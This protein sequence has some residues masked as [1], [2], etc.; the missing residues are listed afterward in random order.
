MAVEIPPGPV[1]FVNRDG[2]RE[3]VRRAIDNRRGRTRPL[4]VGLS[5]PGGSGKTELA[6]ML[7]RELSERFPDVFSVDLDEFRVRG[8]FDAND[9]LGELLG[10]LGVEPALWRASFTARCR[11]YWSLTARRRMVLV[12]DNVRYA[13]EVVPLLPASGDSVVIVVSHGPL[14]DLEDGSALDLVLPPLEDEPAMELLRRIVT[15]G[16][17]EADPDTARAVVRLCS[18]LPAALRVAGNRLRRH[19]L[20]PLPKL[21]ADLRAEL[22]DRGVPVVEA[23][24]DASHAELSHDAAVL[25]RLLAEHPGPTFTRAS[26]TALFGRGP[27]ACDAALEE[28]DG[29]GLV[30]VRAAFRGGDGRMRMPELMRAHARR[31]PYPDIGEREITQAHARVLRWWTRQFQRADLFAAGER[32]TVSAPVGGTAGAADVGPEAPDGAASGEEKRARRRA[33]ARWLYEERHT[34]FAC[35]RLAHARGM[36]DE[37]VALC[38]VLWTFALDHP[39]QSEVVDLYRLGLES[40]LRSGRADRVVRMRC[41]LARPLWEAGATEEAASQMDAAFA[42]LDLLGDSDRDRKLRASAVEFRGMLDAATGDLASAAAR[43]A[44]CRD[45]HAAIPNPYGVMLATYRLGQVRARLGDLD[46][47][48]ELLERAH[49]DAAAQERERMTARTGFALGHVLRRLGRSGQARPLYEESLAGARARRSE[50]DELRVLEALA[51]LAGEEGRGQEAESHRA[52]AE[53]IRRRSGLA[54][55][56][57]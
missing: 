57:A 12:V 38:E 19:R 7:A 6:H 31:R 24:W 45:L 10:A 23:G 42:A 29:A 14:Y 22:S 2:E 11:Q 44:R 5:G 49:R 27:D 32:L 50:A 34:L 46:D 28:L 1:H 13:S 25:Y 30:D 26:A 41:Q 15:D 3:W 48:V 9:V 43:Y 47:A 56:P 21:L 51:E 33:A 37:A 17:L 4:V 52:A 36:D 54:R 8:E 20:R 18:G 53:A 35:V 40:A 39:G 16:R 55:N